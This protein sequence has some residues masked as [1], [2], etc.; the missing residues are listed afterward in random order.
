MI[1][2]KIEEIIR[3]WSLS[4]DNDW[5]VAGHLFDKKDY[6]YALF[7]AHLYLEKLLKAVVV[8]ETGEQAPPIHNLRLLAKQSNL[9][10]S[11][12]QLE[13][14]LQV[15]EYNIRTRYPDFKFKF[16]QECTKEFVENELEKIKEFG[17]WLKKKL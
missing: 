12:E 15:N 5:K 11:D 17:I 8:K 10:L 3:Y 13:F 6:S 9:S 14:L 7:F 4:A 16:K 2:M 1:K